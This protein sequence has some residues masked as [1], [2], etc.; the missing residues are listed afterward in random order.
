MRS[1]FTHYYAGIHT[2]IWG[3]N[4]AEERLQQMSQQLAHVHTAVKSGSNVIFLGFFFFFCEQSNFVKK[5]DSGNFQVRCSKIPQCEPPRGI[6][7]DFD[8]YFYFQ[9]GGRLCYQICRHSNAKKQNIISGFLFIDSCPPRHPLVYFPV[10]IAQKYWSVLK[11]SLS[12]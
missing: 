7:Y 8:L 4:F 10:S 11:R 1:G 3:E 2:L 12:P 9:Y 5:S 6:C